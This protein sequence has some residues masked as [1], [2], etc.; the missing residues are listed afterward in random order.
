[1]PRPAARE[2]CAAGARR[3]G[4]PRSGTASRVD[5]WLVL[6][7]PAAWAGEIEETIDRDPVLARV[8][9]PVLQAV[10]RSRALFIKG[11]GRRPRAT[12][13]FYVAVTDE[14]EPRLYHFELGSD[15]ALAEIDLFGVLAEEEQYEAFR[16]PSPLFLVCTH[17][18]HDRCCAKFGFPLFCELV[19]R[20]P[21]RVWQCSH[22]GGD[23]F[24]ANLVCLPDGGYYGHVE[25]EEAEAILEGAAAGRLHPPCWRGRSC[26]GPPV[27]AAEQLLREVEDEWSLAAYRLQTHRREG[28]VIVAAFREASG[29]R[30]HTLWVE[31]A[32]LEGTRALTCGTPELKPVEGYRLVEHRV[33]AFAPETRS[34][35]DTGFQFR[36][37]AMRDYGFVYRLRR[38]TLV[39]YLDAVA[40]PAEE[41]APFYARFDVMRHRLVQVGEARAGAVSVVERGKALH[42]A[43]LHLLPAYQGLGLGTTIVREIQERAAALRRPV[44]TQVLKVNPARAFYERLG[45][46]IDGEEGLRYRMLWEP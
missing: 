32:R 17:G 31:P 11:P 45:F 37:A 10:P 34:T 4:E 33:S 25:P 22:V 27:Q 1:M 15:L 26:Y 42:L 28:S 39:Q 43:N 21:G 29:E 14:A 40:M 16:E 35:G 8:L 30:Q 36:P 44:T 20:H 23:R 24:A 46:R 6:E 41:Q 2:L 3:V 12:T 13:A 9:R 18:A 19:Q 5:L 38:E 7:V